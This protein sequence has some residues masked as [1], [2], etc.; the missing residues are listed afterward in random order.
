M[1][2]STFA[3]STF[4]AAGINRSKLQI[5]PLG[6]DVQ[7]DDADVTNPPARSTS[8]KVLYA[9]Q[10]TQRKGIGYLAEAIASIPEASLTV[11][12]ESSARACA[13]LERYPRVTM[14]A[15]MP[16]EQLLNNMRAADVFVLPSLAEGFGLVALEAMSVGC[17]VLVSA[18]TFGSDLI[19]DGVNGF[20]LPSTDAADIAVQL[21]R[22]A[23]HPDI[24]KVRARAALTAKGYSWERYEKRIRDFSISVMESKSVGRTS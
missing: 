16:R 8:L 14:L 22:I 19:E 10:V 11:I 6:C 15:S 24:S 7:H 1:V 17:P 21:K 23:A 4:E 12:G 20:V 13:L 3:A 18:N 2:P 9:G 5:L